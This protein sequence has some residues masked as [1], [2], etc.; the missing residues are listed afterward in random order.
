MCLIFL[1]NLIGGKYVPSFCLQQLPH[2]VLSVWCIWPLKRP[3]YE[4][5]YGCGVYRNVYNSLPC[6]SKPSLRW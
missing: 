5:K 2:K 4:C 6:K 3:F 1:K